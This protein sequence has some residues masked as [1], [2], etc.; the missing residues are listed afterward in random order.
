MCGGPCNGLQCYAALI[1]DNWSWSRCKV[2]DIVAYAGFPVTAYA[3]EQILPAVRVVPVPPSV[4]PIVVVIFNGLTTGVLVCHCFTVITGFV[5]IW[6]PTKQYE[7]SLPTVEGM[8]LLE[9]CF[10]L[11]L[12]ISYCPSHRK[13]QEMYPPTSGG[14]AD[15]ATVWFRESFFYLTQVQMPFGA[16]KYDWR[17]RWMC[18][19]ATMGTEA[20]VKVGANGFVLVGWANEMDP[21]DGNSFDFTKVGQQ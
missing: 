21:F 3:E 16:H 19:N 5:G 2:V 18:Y 13:Y 1:R 4:D 6:D 20:S 17:L 12:L 9:V 14:S 15:V 10:L 11:S 7:E 8:G